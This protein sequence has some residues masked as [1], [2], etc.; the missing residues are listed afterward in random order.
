MKRMSDKTIVRAVLVTVG[1]LCGA[2]VAGEREIILAERGKEAAF[3]IV[4]PKT[5]GAS[6]KYA[7]EELR[8]YVRGMTDVELPNVLER[9]RRD[10]DATFYG[11]SQNDWRGYCECTNCAAVDAEEAMR[12]S[13]S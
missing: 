3:A 9:I 8:D 11:V 13:R 7:A 5:A 4:I 10:P 2:T 6:V 12:T 1:L